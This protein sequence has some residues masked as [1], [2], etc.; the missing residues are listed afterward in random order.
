MQRTN[1]D[2]C[3]RP[4][5]KPGHSWNPAFGCRHKC[6]YC[7][8]QAIANRFYKGDFSPRFYPERVAQPNRLRKPSMIFLGSM[9]DMFGV[10]V[11][12]I[13]WDK[14][15]KV[16]Q[17]NP[18]HIFATL[19]K[20]PERIREYLVIDEL[21]PNL[22]L[23]TTVE[24]EDEARRIA[25]VRNPYE[26]VK[27]VRF[28]SFEPLHGR[29]EWD[30]D[31]EGID[32]VIIGQETGHRK[33]KISAQKEWVTELASIATDYGIP[34]WMKNNLIPLIAKDELIREMPTDWNNWRKPVIKAD[35]ILDGK[36]EEQLEAGE[37]H[38]KDMGFLR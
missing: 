13:W 22:W 34:V 6:P 19:T 4:D 9:T 27:G 31:L 2:W 37:L 16:I 7:Y 24:S 8:G 17:D 32:W 1:I 10:W 35:D 3:L 23:G 33:D 11:E 28:V 14:I 18:Q 12:Q 26:S 38:A 21:P 20:A 15:L 36:G 25:W 30:L 5:G 29:F